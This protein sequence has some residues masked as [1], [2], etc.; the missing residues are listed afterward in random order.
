M[1]FYNLLQ[2]K[3]RERLVEKESN[4]SCRF[5]SKEIPGRP[6]MKVPESFEAYVLTKKIVSFTLFQSFSLCS[7]LFSYA[8]KLNFN[9]FLLL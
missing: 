4:G 6:R 3:I 9:V 1:K 8:S 2:K 7:L 5:K